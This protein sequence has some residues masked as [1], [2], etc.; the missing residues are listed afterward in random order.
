MKIL[1]ISE[2]ENILQQIIAIALNTK[3]HF[4]SINNIAANN[5]RKCYGIFFYFLE[6]KWKLWKTKWQLW[7]YV[8]CISIIASINEYKYLLCEWNVSLLLLAN[9]QN[10]AIIKWKNIKNILFWMN[11]A[12]RNICDQFKKESQNQTTAL[13]GLMW[14]IAYVVFKTI[15]ISVYNFFVPGTFLLRSV[16]SF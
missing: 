15:E 4:E 16:N 14:K 13:L 9:K 6:L 5:M 10:K 2:I 8:S 3:W 12:Q 11:N 1:K 7:A